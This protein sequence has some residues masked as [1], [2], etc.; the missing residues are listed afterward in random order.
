MA[1]VSLAR[2]WDLEMERGPDWLF[3]RPRPVGAGLLGAPNLAEQV[4]ALLEQHFTHRLVLELDEV[5]RL[6]SPLIAQLV[7]LQERIHEHDGIMRICGLSS[8]NQDLLRQCSL[9]GRLPSYR[10]REE[11]VMGQSLPKQPR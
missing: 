11:A 9:D 10:D 8:R 3:V 5:G 4:W 6:D 2:G 7:W 1:E